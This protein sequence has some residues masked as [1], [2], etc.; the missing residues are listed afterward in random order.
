MSYSDRIA[1]EMPWWELLDARHE[2][3]HVDIPGRRMARTLRVVRMWRAAAPCG[4]CGAD[5]P[6]CV[7]PEVTP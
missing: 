4:R 5:V 2:R 6:D 3:V 7:C 1:R